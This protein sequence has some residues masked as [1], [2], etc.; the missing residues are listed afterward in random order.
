MPALVTFWAAGNAI[1]E[2]ALPS[3]DHVYTARV[4]SAPQAIVPAASFWGLSAL[5]LAA[6]SAGTIVLAG[7]AGFTT[8]RIEPG[9]FEKSTW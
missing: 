1:N 8:R 7:G 2:N 3:G 5:G 9:E 6:T 4:S